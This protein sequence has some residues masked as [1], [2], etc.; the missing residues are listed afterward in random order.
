MLD[1]DIRCD[2]GLRQA[3]E[4]FLNEVA[5]FFGRAHCCSFSE[6]TVFVPVFALTPSCRASIRNGIYGRR[7][8]FEMRLEDMR[9]Q[10]VISLG[11]VT[12][13]SHPVHTTNRH[14]VDPRYQDRKYLRTE[15]FRLTVSQTHKF[16]LRVMPELHSRSLNVVTISR[17]TECGLLHS[18]ASPYDLRGVA[19]HAL[20]AA[21]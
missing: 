11:S 9:A 4:C 5:F 21:M 6:V 15:N 12:D 7:I 3:V 13:F 16:I 1:W 10:L 17:D 2:T 19:S 14:D 18:F 20:L 8:I